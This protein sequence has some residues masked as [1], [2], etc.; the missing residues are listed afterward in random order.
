MDLVV[1]KQDMEKLEKEEENGEVKVEKR[2]RFKVQSDQ[3]LDTPTDPPAAD[4]DLKTNNTE[5][6]AASPSESEATKDNPDDKPAEAPKEDAETKKEEVV[7]ETKEKVEEKKEVVEEKKEVVEDDKD[8]DITQ[9]EE[10]EPKQAVDTS[11]DGG[12]Y[13]KFD[14]EIGHGSFKTVYKGNKKKLKVGN[15]NCGTKIL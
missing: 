8:D 11:P 3:S 1:E 7:V 13:L 10:E 5:V 9:S 14:E 2:G 12:R 15:K 6:E 4:T